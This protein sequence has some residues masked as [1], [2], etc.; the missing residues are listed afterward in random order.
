MFAFDYGG[1]LLEASGEG[2]FAY[3]GVQSE[4]VEAS[5]TS[6]GRGSVAM[7]SSSSFLSGQTSTLLSSGE[8]SIA[9]GVA[10]KTLQATG[11]GSVAIGQDVQATA[12][13][14]FAFGRD[15]A[16][17]QANSFMIGFDNPILILNTSLII[18]NRTT[19]ING[20]LN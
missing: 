5:M 9:M 2:A 1:G 14:S 12:D 19:K 20:N 7:G 17:S 3:G 6:S 13:N 16:N 10:S 18:L 8:G 15:I 11:Q 4:S